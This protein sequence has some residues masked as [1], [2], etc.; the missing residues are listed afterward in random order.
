MIKI[1]L[2]VIAALCIT[3]SH[4]EL[5]VHHEMTTESLFN[6]P[7]LNSMLANT[8]T[9]KDSYML[10]L[11][12][13]HAQWTYRGFKATQKQFHHAH[14]FIKTEVGHEFDLVKGEL[15]ELTLLKSQGTWMTFVSLPA[16][17]DGK[18]HPRVVVMKWN[19]KVRRF[20]IHM[21]ST[22]TALASSL[23]KNHL[24]RFTSS[25][26]FEA[27]EATLVAEEE[28][29]DAQHAYALARMVLVSAYERI[30]FLRGIDKKS[31][32]NEEQFKMWKSP[33]H[34][35][36]VNPVAVVYIAAIAIQIFAEIW[37]FLANLFGT[38]VTVT[39]KAEIKAK[40]FS[41]YSMYAVFRKHLGVDI[42]D[43]T[44]YCQLLAMVA[45]KNHPSAEKKSKIANGCA[46]SEFTEKNKVAMDDGMIDAA[47]LSEDRFFSL[48]SYMD[49]SGDELSFV[50]M[51]MDATFT[52]A[53]NLL[54]YEKRTSYVGGIFTDSVPVIEE[55][56]R[57][58]SP[59]DIK[60]IRGFNL[61]L[62]MKLFTDNLNVPGYNIPP[63]P[64]L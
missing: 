18:T 49:P 14:G 45:T 60:A 33:K 2:F 23:Q 19:E 46:L 52:L 4:C 50:S 53:P 30:A 40:G 29:A 38:K 48:A 32:W 56:P 7:L 26:G 64:P 44:E 37:G 6:Q 35:L 34:K 41:H 58:V 20:D 36:G 24:I 39:L 31:H 63:H 13:F 1:S 62:A 8:L 42:D 25:F 3:A 9:L 5:Q 43:V 21:L 17:V 57:E 22:K 51:N 55:V 61:G 27:G 11:S 47:K 12:D 16:A 59:D 54:I 28:S 15:E 10:G